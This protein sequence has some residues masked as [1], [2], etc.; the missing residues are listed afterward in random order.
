[1]NQENL[2]G[3]F[4]LEK[5]N[6]RV[7]ESGYIART[8]HPFSD[9]HIVRD[10]SESQPEINTSVWPDAQS[11]INELSRYNLEMKTMLKQQGEYLWPFS[12]PPYIRN[13][14]DIPIAD[15]GL[16]HAEKTEYRKHL[17]QRYGRYKMAFS[18]IH[19]NYSFDRSVLE[20]RFR[21]QNGSFRDLKDRFYLD[22]AKQLLVYGWV[23]T[24]LTA[25]SPIL[26]MSYIEKG[27][28]GSD[29][30]NGMASVRCSELGYW[31]FFTPI[32][33]FTDINAYADSI[34]RY[35]DQDLLKEAAELYYPIRLKPAGPYSLQA[36]RSGGVD[37]VELRMV[38]VNPLS[39]CGL[40]GRDVQF[41]QLF[42]VWL[43][44]L[45]SV[46]LTVKDQ[47]QAVQNFKSAAH[48]DLKTVLIQLPDGTT[49]T[50]VR[51]GRAVLEQMMSYYRGTSEEI[52][53][54]LRFEYEKFEN[55]NNRYANQIRKLYTPHFVEKGLILAKE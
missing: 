20:R 11:A 51:I 34:Q 17:A 7:N 16:E 39:P 37:H 24:C 12:N 19:V 21:N 31:N 29:F 46:A 40:D 44:D 47:V 32:F 9:P 14:Y 28:C 18:G 48:Y 52:Q 5:E 30:F 42:L 36:L 54:I 3:W 25:A 38:D 2:K 43:A 55:E 10:F 33:D 8:P 1:M 53:A 15:F 35:I 23:L 6:L 45:P 4:G 50:A 13:Q 22:L 26:D 27:V 49:G 41:A